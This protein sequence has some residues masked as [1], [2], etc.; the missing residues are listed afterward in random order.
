MFRKSWIIAATA[1]F[2]LAGCLQSDGD[3]AVLCAGAGILAA[4]FLGTDR[5][6]TAVVGAAAGAFCDD[7]GVCN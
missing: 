3:R 6:G 5:A 2:A 7:I 4:D 1:S